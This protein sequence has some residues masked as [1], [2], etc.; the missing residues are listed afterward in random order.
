MKV[1]LHTATPASGNL[2]RIFIDLMGPLVRTK[3]GNQVI[4][5]VMDSFPKFVAFYP[6]RN[7]TSAVVCEVLEKNNFMAYGVPKLLVSDNTRVFKSRINYDFC[8]R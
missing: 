6:V 8:F 3:K 7:I 1:G 5:L 4:M 2:E